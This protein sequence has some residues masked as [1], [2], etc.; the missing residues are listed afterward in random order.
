[1]TK[2]NVEISDEPAG[3]TS[4]NQRFLLKILKVK[5]RINNKKRKPG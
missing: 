1:V 3:K 5:V 2:G 4:D